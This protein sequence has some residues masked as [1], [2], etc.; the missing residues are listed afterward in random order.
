MKR[1][2]IAP[3]DAPLPAF[4]NDAFD[5]DAEGFCAGE[6]AAIDA[7]P[8]GGD[9]RPEARAYVRRDERGLLALL[10]AR[11]DSVAARATEF[12]GEVWKDSCLEWFLKPFG[13]DD[14]YMNIEVNAAGVAL[15]GVG[16]GREGRRVLEACPRGMDIRASGHAGGWWAVAYALPF[17]V[18]SALF[19]Q[20][21]APD[22]ALAGNFY[23][24]DESLHPHFGCWNPINAPKPDFHR[25]EGFGEM[26]FE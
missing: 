11:E 1:Y 23:C 2:I 10:C 22:H 20:P 9:Y 19:G 15:I 21:F 6:Y 5:P 16:A 17:E 14:R 24:C 26:G 4:P 12:G 18:I 13:D 25:P 7:Y 3:A 8:W